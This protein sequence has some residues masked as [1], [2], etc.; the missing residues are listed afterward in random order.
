ME[1]PTV[2]AETAVNEMGDSGQ[3]EPPKPI[4]R[5]SSVTIEPAKAKATVSKSKKKAV[6][7]PALLPPEEA[8]KMC[9][10]QDILFGTSSQLAREESPTF[11]REMQKAIKASELTE[12]PGLKGGQGSLVADAT[13]NTPNSSTVSLLRSSKSLWSVAARDGRG[14]TLDAEIIDLSDTPKA[15]AVLNNDPFALVSDLPFFGPQPTRDDGLWTVLDDQDTPRP[16]RNDEKPALPPTEEEVAIPLAIPRSLAEAT[17][18]KRPKNLS[19]P[20]EQPIVAAPSDKPNFEGYS[21][22]K[23]AKA[24]AGYGF[25]PVKNRDTM[26]K[27]LEQCY[28]GKARLALQS[29]PTNVSPTKKEATMSAIIVD[30]NTSKSKGRPKKQLDVEGDAVVVEK[31]PRR[32]RGRPK[33][34]S[35]TSGTATALPL[36]DEPSISKPKAK[37][38]TKATK[39]TKTSKKAK[40]APIIDDISDPDPLPTPSPPRRRRSSQTTT[41]PLSPPAPNL[42]PTPSTLSAANPT[43]PQSY[44]F[45]KITEA[46]ITF[47]ISA[48]PSKPSTSTSAAITIAK[49]PLSWHEKI[50]LYDPIVLED[51]AAWLNTVGLGRVGVDE[52][53][54]AGTVREWC[55]GRGICCLWRVNLNGGERARW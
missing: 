23:L 50:L 47:P 26:I 25:K 51:L 22:T 13:L 33:K 42:Y 28:D 17:L 19:L 18:R 21:T 24:I 37:S 1:L 43:S 20:T 30:P 9:T 36:P 38:P 6:K 10:N 48:S 52:E 7:V 29:L 11:M 3:A 15:Q 27:L 39:A 49:A 46:I 12:Q 55:E 34:N 31:P 40:S 16:I 4:R 8:L 2:E 53:V 54:S 14:A 5:K 41:L 44:L 35:L 45:S 32:P